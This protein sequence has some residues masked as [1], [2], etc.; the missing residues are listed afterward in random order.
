VTALD[1]TFLNFNPS[2]SETAPGADLDT[3]FQQRRERV[4][5]VDDDAAYIE[6]MKILLRKAGFDVAGATDPDSA[7]SKCDDIHPD[8]I[9]LDLM[10]P[11]MDGWQ[12]FQRVR[13]KTQAPVIVVSASANPDYAVLSLEMGVEDYISKPFYN[14]EIVARIKKGLRQYWQT[15]HEATL[16][17]QDIG[18]RIDLESREV[19]LNKQVVELLPREFA[20][21]TIL[22][23]RSPKN[24]A[25]EQITTRMWG[26]DSLKNRSH[27]KIVAFSL[28]RKLETNPR[29][30]QLIVNNRNIGYQ[31]I[32]KH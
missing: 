4:L 1:T 7:L 23:E 27:L 11:D 14:P 30:P 22:A 10:M 13:E 6:M 9:L 25:Y 12:T 28:R 24:V 18:L 15:K 8:I 32:T 26:E 5:I 3:A 16:E 29:R 31:L 21:L 17:F 19:T 2:I 20:L